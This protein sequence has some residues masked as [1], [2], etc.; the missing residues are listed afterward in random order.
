M[1]TKA[2]RAILAIVVT[3]C[4]GHGPG[5]DPPPERH[6]SRVRPGITVLLQ[7][8]MALVRGKRIALITNQTG[9]NEQG[10]SDIDLLI[11]SDVHLVRI[12][13][14]EHGLRGREDRLFVSNTVDSATGI[15]VYSLY[16]KAILAPPDSLLA[17]LD[18]L[19]FDL[20]DVGTR[21]W[22][23]VGTLIKAMR[24]AAQAHVPVI[25]LDRP[26]PLTGSHVQG[27]ILDS[28]I[29]DTAVAYA[30]FPMPLRHGLTMGELARFYND[31][32]A[33]H[34]AL[35]VI[36]V[37]GWRR[38]LWWDETHLPWIKPS[39]NL[40]SF[41]SEIVYPA[42]VP[43]E[44]TNLSVGRGTPEAFQQLGAP[45]LDAPRV[46]AELS[47]LSL[48]GV[49]F[50]VTE[51]TPDHP[52]DGKY[53]G[54]RLSAVR[55]E[56]TDRDRLDVGRVGAALFWAVARVSRDS[57]RVDTLDFDRRLGS[58]SLRSSLMQGLDPD[59]ALDKTIPS[60][61]AFERRSR[62]YLLYH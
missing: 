46:V 28:T 10:V 48:P 7:D 9:V 56:V 5:E 24:A 45:W 20:Q 34:A 62:R 2:G 38:D 4:I 55:I 6:G 53:A 58:P 59:A 30:L 36:P 60:D 13:S 43:F 27:A 1:T 26:N 25:V 44:S 42:L 35:H 22:T 54:R 14:P 18:F 3:A 21:T 31:T 37:R 49:R 19:V 29:A 17:D 32:L 47:N 61:L 51:F 11:R 40:P 33:L 50:R 41:A 8:S 39:P 12:F 52:T 57:L 23:Y 15:P 16:G